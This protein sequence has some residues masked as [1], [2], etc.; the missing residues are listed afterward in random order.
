M[1]CRTLQFV[2][3]QCFHWFEFIL[4]LLVRSLCPSSS[5]AAFSASHGSQQFHISY[6]FSHNLSYLHAATVARLLLCPQVLVL[7]LGPL[8]PGEKKSRHFDRQQDALVFYT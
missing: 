6:R 8:E 2:K 1:N 5:P 4:P 7:E 3:K